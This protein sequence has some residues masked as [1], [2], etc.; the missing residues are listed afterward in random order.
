MFRRS[1]ALCTPMVTCINWRS[2]SISCSC[3]VG[4]GGGLNEGLPWWTVVQIWGIGEGE[5]LFDFPR[6]D[7]ILRRGSKWR[8]RQDLIVCPLKGR[9]GIYNSSGL[10][11]NGGTSNFEWCHSRWIWWKRS[12][13][14]RWGIDKWR[15]TLRVGEDLDFWWKRYDWIKRDLVVE[16]CRNYKTI[17]S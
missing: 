16:K 10:S 15:S 5:M 17:L 3:L 9:C 11:L 12:W 14:L 1:L 7:M 4:N 2:G 13:G 8:S 6:L